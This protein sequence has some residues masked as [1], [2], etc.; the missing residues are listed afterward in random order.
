MDENGSKED[1]KHLPPPQ[2]PKHRK[3]KSC[4]NDGFRAGKLDGSLAVVKQS[5]DPRSDFRRSMLN[6]IVENK[7]VTGD[8]LRELLRRFLELNAPHHH[9]AI[10]WAFTEIW[11]EVFAA[12]TE[13]RLE[14]P[15]QQP[16]SERHLVAGTV[17]RHGACSN[18]TH[19]YYHV[20]VLPD[21]PLEQLVQYCLPASGTVERGRVLVVGWMEMVERPESPCIE[22]AVARR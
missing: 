8:E 5:E 14:P 20:L 15:R 16:G 22:W 7:I 9:D 21:S 3:A 4:D 12:P 13:L 6:M 11:D 19:C 2:A 18:A 1:G 10:L 17:N